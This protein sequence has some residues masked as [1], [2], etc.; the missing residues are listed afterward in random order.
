MWLELIFGLEKKPNWLHFFKA[1]VQV[2]RASIALH[3]L[4]VF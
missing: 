4:V 3:F 2:P 1:R